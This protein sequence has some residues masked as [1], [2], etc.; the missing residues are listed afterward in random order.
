MSVHPQVYHALK[1]VR[2]LV[3]IDPTVGSTVAGIE[4]RIIPAES[5]LRERKLELLVAVGPGRHIPSRHPTHVEP[6]TPEGRGVQGRH[7]QMSQC[8]ASGTR[9]PP[10]TLTRC[11]ALGFPLCS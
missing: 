8:W 7:T 4:Q 10:S 3:L 1:S 5:Y 6:S 11:R 9:P 2:A